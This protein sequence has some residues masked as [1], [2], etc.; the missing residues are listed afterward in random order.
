MARLL[1]PELPH[2]RFQTDIQIYISHVN[3]GGHLDNAQLLTLV[4]EARVRFFKALGYRESNV[5]GHPIVVGDLGAQYKSEGFHGE[6]LC[7]AMEPTDFN[8]YGF[9]LAFRM[10]EKTTG[11][12]VACGK[13]GIVF[14]QPGSKTVATV[15]AVFVAQLEAMGAASVGQNG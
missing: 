4:S 9:D 13:V 6:T 7:V 14:V 1:F 15:P 11:R 10:T 5:A 8:K 3:Q 12:P 2:Y